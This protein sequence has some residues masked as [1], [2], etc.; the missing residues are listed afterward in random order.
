MYNEIIRNVG[1]RGTRGNIA[2]RG[3][4]LIRFKTRNVTI[5][6]HTLTHPHTHTP[7]HPH[8]NTAHTQQKR[9]KKNIM[10]W[11]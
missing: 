2:V 6:M 3:D 10:S 4:E 1:Q 5:E 11:H 8:T 7:T 9:T